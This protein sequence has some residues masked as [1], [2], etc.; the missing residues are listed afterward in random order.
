MR[1][2]RGPTDWDWANPRANG[3]PNPQSGGRQVHLP[4]GYAWAAP[5][6][7]LFDRSAL[8][9][10]ADQGT[11]SHQS[12]VHASLCGVADV[13]FRAPAVQAVVAKYMAARMPDRPIVNASLMPNYPQRAI[14][15][16]SAANLTL[17]SSFESVIPTLTT[18]RDSAW[19]GLRQRRPV[20]DLDFD[21][22]QLEGTVPGSFTDAAL[23]GGLRGLRGRTSSG[24]DAVVSRLYDTYM[25]AS[26]RLARD[27]VGV[28]ERTTDF[29]RLVGNPQYDP[30]EIGPYCVAGQS[31]CGDDGSMGPYDF[32]LRLL[33]SDLV[34]SVTM[35][36]SSINNTSFDTHVA[37]GP[38]VNANHM[39]LALEQ[40]GRMAIEMS[41]TPGS[42]GGSLQ[43]ET[44]IYVF[45]DFGCTF[46]LV[47]SDHHP[48]SCALLLGGNIAG[49]QMFGAY[50]ET[51]NGSP[52]GTPVGLIEETGE[53]SMRTLKAQD[54]A[55]SVIVAFGV[56]EYFIPGGYGVVE[57]LYRG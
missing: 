24:T 16:P 20:P 44:L 13:N 2:A 10:G 22:A 7:R 45:S 52:M 21:G 30:D 14:G 26:G 37:G 57:G 39:R 38:R 55:A 54:V 27:I 43:D 32:A 40:V 35:R 36:A 33:K 25:A 49:N 28:L 9:V 56:E 29:E 34:T 15:L 41:L 42:G 51:M 8:I 1:P 19:L 46:P 48:A 31:A 12:A 18:R 3:T 17:L 5:A 50:D 23:L 11:A 47:G 6:H 53:R 4:W